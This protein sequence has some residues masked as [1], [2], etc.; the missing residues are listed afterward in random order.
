M[1][2]W[3]N[4]INKAYINFVAPTIKVF[5]HDKKRTNIDPVYAE[6]QFTRMYLPPFT[7][8]AFHL[9]NTWK[10]ILGGMQPYREEEDNIQFVLNFQN[11]VQ[12]VRGLKYSHI[13]ELHIKY[14]GVGNPTAVK[15]GTILIFKVNGSIVG[16]YD[17][18]YQSYNTVSKLGNAINSLPNFSVILKGQNDSSVN[19]VSFAEVTYKNGELVIYSLN[20]LYQNLTDVIEYGDII[21]TNK[22]RIYEVINANPGGDFGWD[23]VTYVISCN[24]AKIDQVILP[25]DYN[26]QVKEHQFNLLQKTNMEGYRDGP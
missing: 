10:Q 23:W 26:K 1:I 2:E 15:T 20:P 17:V 21:L 7:L 12:T 16:Y 18:S 13:A 14:N 4:F 5:K 19:L 3:V 11:M 8:R 25:G 24:L 22:W 6:E 9:D